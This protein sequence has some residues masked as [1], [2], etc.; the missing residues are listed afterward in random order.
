MTAQETDGKP[1]PTSSS[2]GISVHVLNN[3]SSTRVQVFPFLPTVDFWE[4]CIQDDHLPRLEPG[5]F[6]SRSRLL[7]SR[8]AADITTL[9]CFCASLRTGWVS[10][11]NTSHCG[12]TRM[13]I[14]YPRARTVP[15][16]HYVPIKPSYDDLYDTAAFFLGP[17]GPD[18]EVDT[19]LGHPVSYVPLLGERW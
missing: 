6:R 19:S 11:T 17:I 16:L 8:S 2:P 18:G 10:S 12:W 9:I 14:Q 1:I 4:R 15:W 3:L 13:L 5:E 7:A